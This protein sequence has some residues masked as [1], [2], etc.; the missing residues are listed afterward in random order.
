VSGTFSSVRD[1][2]FTHY[3]DLVVAYKQL[4]STALDP[5]THLRS[6][7]RPPQLHFRRGITQAHRLMRAA[8]DV[9]H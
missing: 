4:D 6:F 7:R 1:L 2:P 3:R 9:V 5:A 8:Y